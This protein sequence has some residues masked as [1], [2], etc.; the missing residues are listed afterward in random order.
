MANFLPSLE[1][2]AG[3]RDQTTES[4]AAVYAKGFLGA[5]EGQPDAEGALRE[6][7]EFVTQVLDK[8]PRVAAVFASSRIPPEELGGILEKSIAG[9]VSPHVYRLFQ[10]LARHGRL[11]ILRDVYRASRE[12]WNTTQGVVEVRVTTAH[13]L[14]AG[15][16]EELRGNLSKKL[17]RPVELRAQTNPALLG[18]IQI[19]V[20]DMVHDASVTQQLKS[21]REEALAKT[22]SRIRSERD[23]FAVDSAGSLN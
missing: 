23:R 18:G 8:E 6:F 3:A 12:Q 16:L 13:P 17:N 1:I 14:D 2:Q 15:R 10:V 22:I 21:L 11:G 5:L 9:K 4:I 7:G 19:R 20:G